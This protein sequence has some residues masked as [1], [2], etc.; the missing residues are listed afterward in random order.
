MLIWSVEQYLYIYIILKLLQIT[1]VTILFKSEKCNRA[2][3]ILPVLSC[4]L[5]CITHIENDCNSLN[6]KI[7]A[8]EISCTK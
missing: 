2:L 8:V 5:Y 7:V 1:D 6:K 3:Y 4:G